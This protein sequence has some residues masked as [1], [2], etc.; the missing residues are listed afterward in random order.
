MLSDINNEYSTLNKLEI[1]DS[2]SLKQNLINFLNISPGEVLFEPDLGGSLS[3]T[4]FSNYDKAY[5]SDREYILNKILLERFSFINPNIKI[6]AKT[7][8]SE[9]SILV[10]LSYN[11][12]FKGDRTNVSLQM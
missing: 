6:Q 10:I 12:P 5:L 7:V 1:K 2:E 8:N 9:Y 11:D 4:L 3:D